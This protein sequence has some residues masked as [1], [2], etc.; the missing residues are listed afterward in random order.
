MKLTEEDKELLALKKKMGR[1]RDALMGTARMMVLAQ[2]A[3]KEDYG[4][5]PE[6]YPAGQGKADYGLALS[7]QAGKTA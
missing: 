2:E 3:M 4:L 1:C 6:S 5:L 7:A